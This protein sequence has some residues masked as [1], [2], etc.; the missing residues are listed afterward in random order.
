MQEGRKLLFRIPIHETFRIGALLAIVG[1]FLD[2]YTY[3]LRGG[4]FANAQTGN[5]VLLAIHLAQGRIHT[6]LYYLAPITAFVLGIFVTELI[7]AKS[8][9]I[10]FMK[11]EHFIIAVEILLLA[12]VG[13]LPKEVPNEVVN[14]M[15]SF[16]CSIQVNS[17]R[18]IHNI[19]YASTMC[20]GNLRSGTENLFKRFLQHDKEAGRNASHY[21]G[22]IALFMVGAIMGTL[23]GGWLGLKSIWFCCIILGMV[24]FIMTFKMDH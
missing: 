24:F 17:F 7:K 13:F 3:L 15:I 5:V 6:A 23:L 11:W 8:A 16:I 14:I 19:T 12:I 9:D 22:I 20:T 4:V 18:K 21:F 1:G 10:R 2:A